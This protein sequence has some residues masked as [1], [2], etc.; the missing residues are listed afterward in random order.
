MLTITLSGPQGCG[1]SL[2]LDLIADALAKGGFYATCYD[3]DKL[4]CKIPP[5]RQLYRTSVDL[6]DNRFPAVVRTIQ[7]AVE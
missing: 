6:E 5:M 2:A 3:S 4:V 1:K 7:E